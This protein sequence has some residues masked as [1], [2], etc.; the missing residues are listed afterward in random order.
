MENQWRKEKKYTFKELGLEDM[1]EIDRDLYF[2]ENT[3]R[4]NFSYRDW[5]KV[6]DQQGNME[7]MKYQVIGVI[8][9]K[10]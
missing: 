7:I 3:W 10:N 4:H 9:I 2:K 8:L 6:Y 1:T 5:I